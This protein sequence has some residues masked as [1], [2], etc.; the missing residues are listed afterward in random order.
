MSWLWD[1]WKIPK[2][3]RF[4]SL[5]PST[6]SPDPI[7]K[8]T[9]VTEAWTKV[10][11]ADVFDG[12]SRIKCCHLQSW[13]SG[14]RPLAWLPVCGQWPAPASTWRQWT[15]WLGWNLSQIHSQSSHRERYDGNCE[16][17]HLEDKI[18]VEINHSPPLC[19]DFVSTHLLR[20]Y[21]VQDTVSGRLFGEHRI[22]FLTLGSVYLNG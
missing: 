15:R 16:S 4:H 10:S 13:L 22:W 2:P 5:P 6:P 14:P 1:K 3:H 9:I 8:R 7:D 21:H 12:S 20:V 11:T 19:I 18:S 17:L